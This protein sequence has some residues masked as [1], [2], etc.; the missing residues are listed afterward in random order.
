MPRQNRVNPFGEIFAT[1]AKG[2]FMGNRG[3]LHDAA[4]TIVRPWNGKAWV[5]CALQF[6]GYRRSEMMAPDSYTELF[7][8]DEATAL[9]AGHRP[10]AQCRNADYKAFKT[11]F[12]AAQAAHGA[13]VTSAG[14][15][16][17]VLHAERRAAR[18]AARPADLPD[19][20]I[21]ELGGDAWLTLGGE[22]RR[23]TP[24]DYA[25]RQ[26]FPATE[27]PVLTPP[28]T[29]AVLA[30]GYPVRLHASAR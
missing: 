26:P 13:R 11:R 22:L 2:A 21:V 19:G 14:Q 15:M 12:A 30:A 24:E 18:A 23:W 9:A 3:R 4:K 5:T 6:N 17:H 25:E 29:V 16:D 8:L 7:F 1:S 27:I 20:A 10:C 28:T